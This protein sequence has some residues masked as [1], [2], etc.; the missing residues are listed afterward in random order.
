MVS[1]QRR[2]VL[3]PRTPTI[4][5]AIIMLIAGERSH[6]RFGSQVTEATYMLCNWQG[7]HIR[8]ED[9]IMLI[10]LFSTSRVFLPEAVLLCAWIA[11]LQ[12]VTCDSFTFP[13]LPFSPSFGSFWFDVNQLLRMHPIIL[14]VKSTRLDLPLSSKLY[15]MVPCGKVH[16]R[17]RYSGTLTLARFIKRNPLS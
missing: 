3:K 14:C 5:F 15:S 6:G 16:S 9:L 11:C 1:H 2:V 4:C 17:P 13:F 7:I 8:S 10:V 12:A